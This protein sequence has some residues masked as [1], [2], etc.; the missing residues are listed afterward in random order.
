M[1]AASCGQSC[2]E[3]GI[4]RA[5]LRC[6]GLGN[7]KNETFPV[8]LEMKDLNSNCRQLKEDRM[9]VGLAL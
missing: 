3:M 7:A 5:N 2:F 4:I 8:N 1:N 9:T 6:V